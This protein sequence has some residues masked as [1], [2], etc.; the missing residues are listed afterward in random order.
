LAS[1][2]RLSLQLPTAGLRHQLPGHASIDHIAIPR[3]CLATRVERLSAKDQE[4][5]LSDHDAYVV[6]IDP[7]SQKVT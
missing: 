1:I 7:I 3:D 5:S 2:D 4:A 6:E